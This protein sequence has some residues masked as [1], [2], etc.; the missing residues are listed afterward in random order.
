[1]IAEKLITII[2][3]NDL[4]WNPRHAAAWQ[5]QSTWKCMSFCWS[6]ESWADSLLPVC[7]TRSIC[8]A[9]FWLVLSVFHYCAVK[10][11]SIAERWLENHMSWDCTQSRK[12][13]WNTEYFFFSVSTPFTHPITPWFMDETSWC[14]FIW[15]R[16]VFCRSWSTFLQFCRHRQV[17]TDKSF[18]EVILVFILCATYPLPNDTTELISSEL[19][20]VPKTMTTNVTEHGLSFGHKAPR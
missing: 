15:G 5:W 3:Y 18:S 6:C 16:E 19:S 12:F 2:L 14:L 20:S 8:L 4:T 7:H 9:D 1:M 10:L 17:I 11:R 13:V